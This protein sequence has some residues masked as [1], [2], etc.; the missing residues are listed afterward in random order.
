M[1]NPLIT[2]LMTVYNGR[3]YLK[4]SLES[5]L[6]Q[7]FKDFELLI[8]DDASRDDSLEIIRSYQTKDP[9]IVIYSNPVNV[10]QTKSLNVGLNLARGKYVAR[11]DADDLVFP[12][13]LAELSSFLK[14]N[15]E[16][17][18][19]SAKAVV[20]N[21]SKGLVRILNTPTQWPHIVLKSLTFSPINHVGSLM[22]KDIILQA[23][24][25]DETYH[26]PADFEL[27]SRLMRNGQRLAV[28]PQIL[29]AIRFH[30]ENQS[31]MKNSE[32]I[33]KIIYDNVRH[34]T[35]YPLNTREAGLLYQLVYET[36]L[37]E[38]KSFQ[39]A[40]TIFR[41]VYRK[42]KVSLETQSIDKILAEQEKTIY[43]K[44]IFFCIEKNDLY[45]IRWLAQDYMKQNGRGNIFSLI[46]LVSLAG[47][48]ILRVLPKVYEMSE[49][50]RL[51]WNLLRQPI[52][53]GIP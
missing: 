42:F 36:S 19:V 9:R 45:N 44:R 2:I 32:E 3:T 8:I 51:Q 38:Q 28:L 43:I 4:S 46:W 23:G 10:G 48:I 5:V 24:K 15:P 27:W 11:M 26:V 13:W 25:Y 52:P 18:V 47:I 30:S 1:S 49:R 53:K 37:L 20:M 6:N 12:S 41:N 35:A 14:E 39:E 33:V 16:I 21:G 34:W 31:R 29:I 7:T 22:R 40:R 17:A 50:L